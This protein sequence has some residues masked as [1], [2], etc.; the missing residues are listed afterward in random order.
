MSTQSTEAVTT[1]E[2]APAT[3]EPLLDTVEIA[4]LAPG[5]DPAWTLSEVP[6][7]LRMLHVEAPGSPVEI[8]LSAPLGDTAGYWHPKAG[9]SRTLV[10]DWEGRSRVSLIDGLAAGCLY[11]Y[12]GATLLAFAAADPVPEVALRFGVSEENDTHVVHLELPPS[13]TPHRILFVPRSPSVASAMRLLR[14]WYEKQTPAAMPVPEAARLPLYCTWYAFNQQVDAT[15]VEQQAALAADM[16]FG[17][18]ILDDG[19]QRFGSGRGYAGVGDWLPDPDKFPDFATHVTRV[20]RLGLRY[21][22]WVAP[23]LLGPRTDCYEQWASYAPA[24]AKVPGAH[25]LDPRSPEVRSHVVRLCVRLV[26]AYGLDGLKV[27]FLDE[28]MAYA[29]DGRGDVGQALTLL[30]TELRTALL[31][32]RSDLLLELRQPYVG[33]GMAAFG[34]MLRSFDCPADSTANRVRTID[35]ALL[36][37]GGVVHSDPLLW[38]TTAPATT[39]AR[40]LIGALHSV[41]QVSVRLDALPEDHAEAVR[42]WLAQWRRLRPQLLDGMVEPGRPDDLYTLV[43]AGAD[44][45]NVVSVFSDRTVPVQPAVHRETVLINAAAENRLV[46][47]VQDEGAQVEAEIRDPSGRIIERTRITLTPGLHNLPVP[48]MGLALI[49]KTA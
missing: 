19:W 15:A 45:V 49:R 3:F 46:L 16:G 20:R 21:M 4:V 2:L 37:V 48:N 36:A 35:T 26:R 17:T 38:D 29:G 18:L 28:A 1:A 5:A 9:W 32:E 30:L 13:T 8:R 39:A 43:R 14:G 34:N 33:P 41:P 12:S 22:A 24:L 31:A 7:G 25:V 23:L 6:G 10:A 42:F 44:G 27:D 40:Q 11:D 47:E